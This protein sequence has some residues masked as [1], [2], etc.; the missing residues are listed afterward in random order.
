MAKD[1]EAVVVCVTADIDR[2][3]AAVC[4]IEGGVVWLESLYVLPDCRN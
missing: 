4:R 1:V 3:A 2:L